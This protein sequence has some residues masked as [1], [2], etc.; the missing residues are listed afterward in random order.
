MS[1]RSSKQ[2]HLTSLQVF[3]DKEEQAVSDVLDTSR[4][5]SLTAGFTSDQ[6]ISPDRAMIVI[7]QSAD[8]TDLV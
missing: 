8:G 7:E 4:F 5:N 6:T 1:A 2:F 3:L